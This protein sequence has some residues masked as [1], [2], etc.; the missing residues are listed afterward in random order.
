MT[1]RWS[2]PLLKVRCKRSGKHLKIVGDAEGFRIL[3]LSYPFFLFFSQLRGKIIC[4]M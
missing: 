3:F 4:E 1:A 2:L